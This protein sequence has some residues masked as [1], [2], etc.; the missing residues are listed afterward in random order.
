MRPLDEVI[1]LVR[2]FPDLPPEAIFKEDILRQGLA[3][4]PEALQRAAS[5]KQK[6]Y[7][8]FSFD[9]QPLPET[10]GSE[11]F[12]APEEVR[13]CGGPYRFRPTVI[14]VR[15][16]PQSEYRIE[17]GEEGDL[18]L[19]LGGE[20]LC[21]V[22]YPPV[23][24]YY[25]RN[26]SNGK[27]VIDICPTIEWGYLLYLAVY[28][29]CQYS[30]EETECR[31]CDINHNFRRRQKSG[32]SYTA[33]KSVEEVLEALAII[34]S[35]D[36]VG[37]AY[38][39]TGGSIFSSL[40]G[41]R[42][43]EFYGKYAEAI[44]RRFPGRWI[45]KLVAQALARPDLQRLKEYGLSIYH[46]N[47]E[48]WDARLFELLCPGKAR[49]LGRDLWMRR[50]L[51]AAGIFGPARVIP[52]F[53]AGVEMARPHGFPSVEE[54]LQSTGEGL[55]FYMSQG[56]CP[57]FT[58]WCPEPMSQ[59]GKSQGGAPLEYHVGLLRLWRDTHHR[60]RLPVPPGYGPPGAGHAV[61]SVSA[62]MDVLPEY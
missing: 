60:Y 50:I 46:P 32:Q 35:T 33:I 42:E 14:S 57:R 54:A 61:F 29:L 36:V 18:C 31:F 8:I 47:F 58:T 30:T 16:H 9:L 62:F 55:D 1:R 59:L 23:P 52:N 48:V 38:T 39:L 34:A 6:S 28:R 5:K 53:V 17:V 56:I 40:N 2:D 10:A 49:Y 43:A 19:S 51:D 44:E 37:Q 15:N 45:G 41:E 27:P 25:R 26:L 11:A 3:F 22:E 4:S 24:E 12:H 21:G 7:F 20:I 13:L